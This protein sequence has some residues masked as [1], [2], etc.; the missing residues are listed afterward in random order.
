MTP[1]AA[2]SSNTLAAPKPEDKDLLKPVAS[3]RRSEEDMK[4][5]AGSDASYDIVSGATSRTPG[6]PK[7]E[8]KA[9]VAASSAVKEEESDE[10][11]WE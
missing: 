11:D 2:R 5:T 4:S 7:E 6:S 3:P 9:E 1:N 8:K 10:E